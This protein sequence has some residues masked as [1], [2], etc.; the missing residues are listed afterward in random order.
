[1]VWHHVGLEDVETHRAD[2]TPEQE[3]RVTSATST[4]LALSAVTSLDTATAIGPGTA[5]DAGQ[6]ISGATLMVVTTGSPT[7]FDVELEVSVDNMVWFQTGA[8]ITVSGTAGNT[9]VKG[10]YYRAHLTELT[11]GTSPTVTAIIAANHM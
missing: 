5:L 8:A 1:M 10:Q 6:I 11:G 9:E 7:S 2:I 4:P 3:L